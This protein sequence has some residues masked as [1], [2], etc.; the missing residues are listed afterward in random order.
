MGNRLQHAGAIVRTVMAVAL[1]ASLMGL[2]GAAVV[3]GAGSAS[4]SSSVGSQIVA[5]AASQAGVPYCEGGGGVHGPSQPT[6][7]MPTCPAPGYDC[8]SLA[9]YAVYQ[10]TGITVPFGPD[11]SLPGQGTLIPPAGSDPTTDVSDLDPGDVVFFGGT[12]LDDYAHS[13]I[14]A[15]GGEVWDDLI[16]GTVV[17]EHTFGQLDNDYGQDYLG[18]VRYSGGTP[19]PP[20]TTTTSTTST[21]TP[22]PPPAFGITT[23]SLAKATVSSRRHPVAYSQTL[24]ATGG[25]PPYVWSLASGSLPTGLRLARS[26]TI[27]GKAK[28]AGTFSFEVK[29]VDGKTKATAK[30]RSN[31]KG[32]GRTRSKSR[33]TQQTA[34]RS[35]SITVEAAA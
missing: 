6:N 25:T 24:A 16:P 31:R 8:M 2:A 20:T 21:T 5:D 26:G 1:V 9:Q 17:Q 27:S 29:V 15:G 34:E 30:A 33:S 23:T 13:G 7:G 22:P 28:A 19:P 11:I 18:A 10:A 3:V 32:A 14:Y 4:A 35:L 12:S